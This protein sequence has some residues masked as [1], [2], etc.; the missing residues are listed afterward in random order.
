[1]TRQLDTHRFDR[2]MYAGGRPNRVA[3][4]LNGIWRTVASRGLS[5]HRLNTLEVPG[6]R[7]GRPTSF[8]V[9][10][11]DYE[12]ER[13][14]VAMLGEGA[15]WVANVRAAGGRAVLRH[16]GRAS[17]QLDEVDPDARAP[18]LQRSRM[19]APTGLAKSSKARIASMLVVGGWNRPR[20]RN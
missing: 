16:G 7:S 3:R 13:Y 12:G 15:N 18:I 11:A 1:M 9:V 20:A 6:R 10:V 2:W 5:P 14:V 17:V 19:K 8:P 4:V